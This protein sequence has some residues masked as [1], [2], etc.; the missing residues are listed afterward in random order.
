MPRTIYKYERIKTSVSDQQSLRSLGFFPVF[1]SNVSAIK[2]VFSTLVIRFHNGSVYSYPN[3]GDKYGDLLTSPSKGKWVWDNL[4]R[5]NVAYFKGDSIPLSGDKDLTDEELMA[6]LS[7]A[8][9]LVQALAMV[10]ALS[11]KILPIKMITAATS[12]E[13]I[14]NLFIQTLIK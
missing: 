14:S 13:L 11:P 5:K 12:D 2:R 1:S 9:L 8:G 3:S 6:S 4:R 10:E 7:K